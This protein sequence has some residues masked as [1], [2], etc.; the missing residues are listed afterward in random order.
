M[1]VIHTP[2]LAL[3]TWRPSDA[4]ALHAMNQDPRVVEHLPGPM[5]ME[6]VR[7]FM[8]TQNALY[9]RSSMCYL[10]ATLAD[11]AS[12]VGFVGLRRHPPPPQ[13]AL[14]FA[15]C[16]EIGWR[17]GVEHWGKGYAREAAMACLRH[18][19]ERLALDE[20]LSFTVPENLRSRRLMEAL[21]MRRDEAGDFAHPAL[22]PGH[23][24]SRH[25]LYRLARPGARAQVQ[26][27]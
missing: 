15:P 27:D 12:L 24:L 18:G 5:S 8:A 17:L 7:S 13:G 9:E 11:S 16:T 3:R 23:R 1:Y 26:Q 4:E 19:F 2:R 25:V 22:P 10:A 14:P 21:G 6:Q 20:I